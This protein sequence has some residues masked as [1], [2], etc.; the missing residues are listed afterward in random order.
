MYR[1]KHSTYRV[2]SYPW[3]QLAIG[4]FGIYPPQ[5]RGETTVVWILGVVFLILRIHKNAGWGNHWEAYLPS[6]A[7][8]PSSECQRES[9]WR[10]HAIIMIKS[11]DTVLIQK[12]ST[13]L[14]QLLW[15]SWQS[16]I[17][18]YR[19]S[20]STGWLFSARAAWGQD[21]QETA[22]RTGG[23]KSHSQGTLPTQCPG[24]ACQC[25]KRLLLPD[26]KLLLTDCFKDLVTKRVRYLINHLLVVIICWAILYIL[27]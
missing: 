20:I 2:W 15:G 5:V 24:T 27:D 25:F 3:L 14:I 13:W 10:K 19:C 11:K 9:S 6:S 23:L 16:R 7:A 18:I 21:T 22:Y 4:G 12:N 26:C 1:E 17:T 8:S